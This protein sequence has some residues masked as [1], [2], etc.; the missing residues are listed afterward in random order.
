MTHSSA[1]GEPSKACSTCRETK[2]LTAFS[3]DKRKK[4]GRQARCLECH[5]AYKKRR[6]ADNPEHVR[7]LRQAEYQRNK[8]TYRQWQ[9]DNREKRAQ[10]HQAWEASLTPEQR[11]ARQATHR[12]ASAAY[13]ARNPE[14]CAERIKAWQQA[15]PDK[16]INAVHRR[17][18]R[19]RDNGDSEEF[20]REEIGQ[21][22]GW[23]CGI[24]TEPVDPLLEW[25]DLWSQSLD[26]VIPLAHGGP[27]TRANSR[28]AHWICNVRRGANRSSS[29]DSHN[30]M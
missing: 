24:C 9:E 13:L 7:T 21:R 18:A 2:P 1:P 27:H 6:A 19:K 11:E 26:H 4:D 15:N 23:I 8:A 12:A 28:I 17:R 29:K 10:W 14:L 22:D 30:E 20:T 5:S 25:P 3:T 16:G